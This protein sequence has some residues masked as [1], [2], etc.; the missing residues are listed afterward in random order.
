MA[1]EYGR[2]GGMNRDELENEAGR[3]GID[4]IGMGDEELRAALQRND[5]IV[6]QERLTA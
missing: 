6:G 2:F 3:S 4:H 5:Q 1:V